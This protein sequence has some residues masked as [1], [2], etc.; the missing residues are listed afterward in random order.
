VYVFFCLPKRQ[1][2]PLTN[3]SGDFTIFFLRLF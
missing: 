2:L 1:D 3:T